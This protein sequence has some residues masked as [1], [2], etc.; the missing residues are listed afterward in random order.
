MIPLVAR[1]LVARCGLARPLLRRMTRR[2]IILLYHGVMPRQGNRDE[3]DHKHVAESLFEEQLEF[4][5]S[6]YEI[7]P[8]DHM[9]QS[10]LRG[11]DCCGKLVITFIT[12]DGQGEYV[13]TATLQGGI[14]VGSSTAKHRNMLV[15]WTA[16]REP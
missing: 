9:I 15:P 1:K 2:P 14:L 10:L 5:S 6:L 12:S 16:T 13:H 11:E 7:V 4:L 8:L 3:G